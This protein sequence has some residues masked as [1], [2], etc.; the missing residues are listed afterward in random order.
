MGCAD[1]EKKAVIVEE[2]W[3]QTFGQHT[4]NILQ[5]ELGHLYDCDHHNEKDLDCNMN[6]YYKWIWAEWASFP[7]ELLTENWCE[8]C[9]GIIMANRT[10]IGQTMT[11]SSGS[12]YRTIQSGEAI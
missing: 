2:F 1:R 10:T 6:V 11:G 12:R 4:D 8:V 9:E 3:T 7:I 5:H